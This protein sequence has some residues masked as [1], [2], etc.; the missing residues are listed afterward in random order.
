MYKIRNQTFSKIPSEHEE[1]KALVRYLKSKSI[2]FFAITNENNTFKQ[3]RKYAM[4]A[5]QKAKTQGKLKG[6]PDL[7]IFL[8]DKILFMELKVQRPLLKSGKL[9][10]PRNKPTFEQLDFIE[11]SN[12]Y[13]YCESYVAYGC[14]E[15][16]EILGV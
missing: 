11:K 8:K 4:I 15:A 14:D 5:E 10:T 1:Q 13:K 7:C 9:G 12:K 16:I 2:F 6:T 3:N